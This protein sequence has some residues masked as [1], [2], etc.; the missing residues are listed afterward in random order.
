MTAIRVRYYDMYGRVSYRTLPLGVSA[1][2]RAREEEEDEYRAERG[3]PSIEE[4]EA[5][6]EE[7]ED[8]AA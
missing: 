7:E 1:S 8:D 5:R 2:I 4:E 6:F 3:L